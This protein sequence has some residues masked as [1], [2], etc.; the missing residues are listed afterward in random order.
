MPI[1][2]I[3]EKVKNDL[4]HWRIMHFQNL[5]DAV[6]LSRHTITK[7]VHFHADIS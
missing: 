2:M 4:I 1:F 7:S 3:F 6:G 5:F